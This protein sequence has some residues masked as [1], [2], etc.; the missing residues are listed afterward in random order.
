MREF[1]FKLLIIGSS[2]PHSA[3]SVRAANVVIF[4][5]LRA[6]A[7]KVDCRVGYLLVRRA[8]D[9]PPTETELAGL[10]ELTGVGVDVLTPVQLPVGA[11]SRPPW[12]KLISSHRS[13]FYPDSIHSDLVYREVKYFSPDMLLVPWS[14]WLTAL[15]ADFPTKKFAYY[16][17]PDH[18]SG[19]WRLA[20]DRRHGVSRV[21]GLRSKIALSVLEKEHLKVMSCYDLVGN[22]A[23]N[24]AAYYARKGHPNAFYIQNI[25][26][27]RFADTWRQRRQVDAGAAKPIKI[28]ANVGQL[29]ATANRYGLEMLGESVA[30]RLREIM[31]HLPYELH[32]LGRGDLIPSLGRLLASPEIRIRGFVD[33]ID[34]EMFESAIFLCLNNAS[35]FKVGHTRYLHA[36][37]LGMCVVAH[38]DAALSMPEMQHRTNCLLGSEPSDIAALVYEAATQKDLRDSLGAAGYATFRHH[39][40][41]ETVSERIW[42]FIDKATE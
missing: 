1:P 4:E 25:W 18:K 39:F 27:D 31:S 30:P 8:S 28:I 5:L 36:W 22:V 15:C 41:A 32:I 29:G 19:A 6:L 14:E 17:N 37:S 11:A 10:A 7:C 20:F 26:I 38:R 3:H 2:Y 33:D 23:A 24:D 13:D 9:P 35:P 21:S 42:A 34:S 12:L 16:G 40:T